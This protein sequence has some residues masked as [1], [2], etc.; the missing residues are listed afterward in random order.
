MASNRSRRLVLPS[1][2]AVSLIG[3][4]SALLS[5]GDSG[6][7]KVGVDA[8]PGQLPEDATVVVDAG[9]T[10]GETPIDGLV[11]DTAMP[12]SPAPVDAPIDSA[13]PI[14]APPDAEVG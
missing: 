7:K 12:D 2:L 1:V 4:A 5:C 10:D 13:P 3:G 6:D 9:T 11:A 8:L 14:D